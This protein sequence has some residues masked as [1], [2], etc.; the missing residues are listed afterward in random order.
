[1][2]ELDVFVTPPNTQRL[3]TAYIHQ[4][5]RNLESVDGKGFFELYEIKVGMTVMTGLLLPVLPDV[6]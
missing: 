3:T 4:I 1:M 6:Q 2:L 5:F